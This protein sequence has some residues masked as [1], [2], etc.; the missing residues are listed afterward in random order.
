MPRLTT[1]LVLLLPCSLWAQ[2]PAK[3]KE[4]IEALDTLIERERIDAGIPG[5]S[6]AIV[7]DQTMIWAKGFGHSDLAK[8][9]PATP[10][11]VYRVGSVSKLF[12]DIAVMQLVEE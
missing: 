6:V 11:S 12:T 4:A 3:Y 1:L 5:I 9:R 2:A 10:E 8:T 7:D